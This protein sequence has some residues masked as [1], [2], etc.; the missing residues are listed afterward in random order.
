MRGNTPYADLGDF[1]TRVDPRVV[2][3]RTLETLVNAGAFDQLA[4]RR[5]QAFAAIDTIIGTA[6]RTAT[7]KSDG[8]VDMF[9]TDKPEPIGMPSGFTPWTHTERLEREFSAIGFHLSG[10]PLDAYAELFEQLRVQRWTDFER[11]VGDGARAGRL[12][13]TIAGRNDRRTKKGTPMAILSLSDPSGGFECVVFSEQLVTS[14]SELVV[15]SSV[16]IEVEADQRPDGV[17]IR[18]IRAQA[19]GTAAE[20]LGRRLTVFAETERCLSPIRA[21]L[22]PGGEGAVSFVVIRDGGAREYEIALPGSFRLTA[23]LASGIKALEG[24]MDVRLN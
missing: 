18:L 20:K 1:A 12:A 7:D 24:V 8:I 15:G 22:K 4:P 10:H 21:Q 9:A 13:A 17:S 6:Q 2:N 3:R 14:G 23:E 11:A 16:V 5:E 19:I